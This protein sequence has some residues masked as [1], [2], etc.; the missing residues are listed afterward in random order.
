MPYAS[1][2]RRFLL[3][4]AIF[5]ALPAAAIAVGELAFWRIGENWPLTRVTAAQ[6]RNPE[7]VFLRRRFPE[8][9]LPYK[10]LTMLEREASIIAIGSSR[11][12]K[13]RSQLFG[14][15]AAKFYNFGAA[16]DLKQTGWILEQ[17]PASPLP[18][19]LY[20]VDPWWFNKPYSDRVD[21]RLAHLD[22]AAWLWKAHLTALRASLFTDRRRVPTWLFDPIANRLGA[23]AQESGSGFRRDGS[24]RGI[25]PAPTNEEDWRYVER[26]VPPVVERVHNGTK[27]YIVTTEPDAQLLQQFREQLR[28]LRDRGAFVVG[29][30]PPISVEVLAAIRSRPEQASYADAVA[31]TIPP[32]FAEFG[33]PFFDFSS[34]ATLGLDDTYLIDGMHPEETYVAHMLLRMLGDPRVA[35][36]FPTA[37]TA[38]RA[39]LDDPATN[40]W[41]LTFPAGK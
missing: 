13:F 9:L 33:F 21:D 6:A 30:F 16:S 8:Q 32:I 12:M 41:Y 37:E 19:V 25:V 38:I 18:R 17:I 40:R 5:F 11:V 1:D 7:A 28:V 36:A 34:T 20:S 4:T 39:A 26:E 15:E 2:Q 3:R 14:G 27:Q 24:L 35:A 23:A 31:K 29:F 10:R 22:D